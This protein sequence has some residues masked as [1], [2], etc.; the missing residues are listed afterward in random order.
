MQEACPSTRRLK[1]ASFLVLMLCTFSPSRSAG[2]QSLGR[3]AH[4]LASCFPVATFWGLRS[5]V[6]F[7]HCAFPTLV[8]GY[9][10]IAA[11][12]GWGTCCHNFP[13]CKGKFQ[14][15]DRRMTQPLWRTETASGN[16]QHQKYK[17]LCRL[18]V[19]P[20]ATWVWILQPFIDGWLPTSSAAPPFSSPISRCLFRCSQPWKKL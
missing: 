19:L 14:S 13:E 1:A 15:F 12:L 16:G 3:A 9:K 2:W 6:L 17:T 4:R 5:G 8:V 10:L 18:T 20:V 7:N 11:F